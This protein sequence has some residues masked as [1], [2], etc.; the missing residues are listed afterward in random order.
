MRPW[1]WLSGWPWL[2]RW[3]RIARWSWLAPWVLLPTL[4]GGV[5]SANVD[6]GAPPILG[7][8]RLSVVFLLDGQ[9]YF[10][11]LEDPPSSETLLLRD[12][13]YFQEARNSPTNLAL[14][15]LKRGSELH[16]PAD[17]LRIR[18]DKVVAIELV[19]PRSAVARAIAAERGL[20]ALRP[21]R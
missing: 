14:A 20:E 16:V 8:E 21:L 10:G 17:G 3:P 19:G 5:L 11:H 9:A 2:G 13:Y 1:R 15:L 4:I 12:V 18:R 7:P 6:R